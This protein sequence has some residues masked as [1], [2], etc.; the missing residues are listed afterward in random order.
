MK[1]YKIFSEASPP[2]EKFKC[3]LRGSP[4]NGVAEEVEEYF[5]LLAAVREIFPYVQ[6]KA[7]ISQ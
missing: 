1:G 7:D 3:E 6:S 2:V 5:T 4:S